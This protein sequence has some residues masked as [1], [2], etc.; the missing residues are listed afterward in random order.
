MRMKMNFTTMKLCF[1]MLAMWIGITGVSAQ[2][3][4]PLAQHS[5]VKAD[6]KYLIVD[7]TKK[8]IL[9]SS[10]GS[11]GAPAYITVDIE[12]DGTIADTGTFETEGK[13]WTF[14]ATEWGYYIRPY[15]TENYLYSI[16]DNNGIRVGSTQGVW[17]LGVTSDTY[18]GFTTIDPKSATRYLGVFGSQDWRGYTSVNN[19]IKTTSI[20]VF[21]YTEGSVSDVAAPT[22]SLATGKYRGA[23][24]VTI[25]AEDGATVYYTTDG[26]VPTA[27]STA[28]AG[29]ISVTETTTLKAIAVK[30]GKSSNVVTAV[31]TIVPELTTVAE[32]KQLAKGEEAALT[33]TGAVVTA[34][35]AT[36]VY[37]EDAT[38]AL[39]LYGNLPECN[40]GDAVGGTMIGAYDQFN[41]SDELTKGDYTEATFTAG[42]VLEPAEKT[43]DELIAEAARYNMC[44][45]KVKDLVFAENKIAQGE[46]TVAFYDLLKALPT[47]F[48]WP[49]QFE[50]TGLFLNYRG[51]TPQLV[52]RSAEEIVNTSVLEVPEFAWSIEAL[53]Y[54]MANPVELPVLTN[55]SDGALTFESSNPEVASV[56]NSGEVT[57]EAVGTAVITATVAASATFSAAMSSYTITVVDTGDLP[58]P[59]AFVAAAKD[60]SAYYAMMT[61]AANSSALKTFEV[62]AVNGKVINV[63]NPAELS[64][65]VNADK[66]TI[67]TAAG[68]YLTATDSKTNLTLGSKETVWTW[69]ED[70]EAWMM[71]TRSFFA[72]ITAGTFKNYAESN[73]KDEGKTDYTAFSKAMT[74]AEGRVMEAVPEAWSIVCMPNAVAEGDLA[75]AVFYTLKGKTENDVALVLTPVTVLEAGKPYF[76][77]AS[78]AKLVMAYD[79]SEAVEVPVA[80]NGMTGTFVALEDS[81]ALAGVCVLEGGK[82]MP[83]T[84]GAGVAAG[85]AYVKLGD[86][87]VVAPAEG[88]VTL[89]I[90]PTATSIDEVTAGVDAVVT[91][92]AADGSVVRAN[93]RA[94]RAFDGL[95]AGLYIVKG[96]K[97]TVN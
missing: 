62:D 3:W 72:D 17:T 14:E 57:V 12:S 48:V 5:D 63:E 28:Y 21:E 27:E 33:L 59:V 82:L 61:T 93:V 86:V 54:D 91:V 68:Q 15:G 95:P 87:P 89:P 6:G 81:E 67:Q 65:Y 56:D 22:L 32:F 44:L 88:D 19:N 58:D 96:K 13:V 7:V 53:T 34:K 74:F 55:N 49:A 79:G 23:Q 50:M 26:S 16:A 9:N 41:G 80:V 43:L 51:N 20:Q 39:L 31:Y 4:V 47:D 75:G 2:N 24:S 30:D 77:R 78:A 25:T 42:G 36:G 94:N 29:A 52:A 84:A 40:V 60:G 73:A 70:N 92:Y 35:S 10:K 45:V 71:G 18:M 11:S 38:G 64:W 76:Y 1:A 97:V 90:D 8:A 66:G 85:S 46:T 69:N 37:I 83:Y